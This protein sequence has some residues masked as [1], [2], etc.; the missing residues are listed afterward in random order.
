[1][2][3][4]LA[5][6]GLLLGLFHVW[7]LAGQLWDGSLADPAVLA[8]WAV[9]AGLA[10][11][12]AG[13]WRGATRLGPRRAVAIWLL[14]TLLHAPAVAKRLDSPADVAFPD[15]VAT[16]VEVTLSAGAI[17]LLSL[18]AWRRRREPRATSEIPSVHDL[19]VGPLS[20][21]I[22]HS[23]SARPPPLS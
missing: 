16:L 8:R 6:A 10:W 14:A 2:R 23:W 20:S 1:M 4:I 13:A 21:G 15:L 19:T 22:W 3:R 12:L 9:S 11:L 5:V 17:I 18:L 7:L